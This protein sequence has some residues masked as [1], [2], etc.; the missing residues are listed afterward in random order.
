MIVTPLGVSCKHPPYWS[1][2]EMMEHFAFRWAHAHHALVANIEWLH[3][4][5]KE[6]INKSLNERVLSQA[7]TESIGQH[8]LQLIIV[9]LE[10]MKFPP[11]LQAKAKRLWARLVDRNN[12][13]AWTADSVIDALTDLNGDIQKELQKHRFAHLG[14]GVDEYFENDRL[15]GSDVYDKFKAA[16][17]DV[18]DA[19]NCF[20]TGLYTA[21]VFHL[22]RVAEHGFR[23]IAKRFNVAIT[24]HGKRIPLEYGTWNEV[25]TAIRNQ[26]D[27]ARHKVPADAKRE[28]RLDYYSDALDRLFRDERAIQKSCIAYTR[29]IC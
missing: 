20:A 3:R 18:K 26:F 15:F 19:G 24:S 28:A 2:F 6:D 1:L 11:D 9:E 25:L 5:A 10:Q 23:L 29:F 17:Q 7:R 4:V 27:K 12:W 13:R 21:C 22:M 14:A 16:R 8:A